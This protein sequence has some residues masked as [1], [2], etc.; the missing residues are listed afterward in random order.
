MSKVDKRPI[1]RDKIEKNEK[2][3]A[4]GAR[5]DSAGAQT[6]QSKT[7]TYIFKDGSRYEGEYKEI[8]GGVIVR[9]GVGKYTCGT[10]KSVYIGAW[11]LD[12]MHGKGRLEFA[13]GAF[14]DGMWKENQYT[15]PGTYRWPDSSTF[16]GEW[17]E[18]GMNGPG[19]YT[20]ASGQG[21]IGAIFKGARATL[22]PELQ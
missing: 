2:A 11:E 16:V 7:G 18:N 20:D 21:W 9:S 3:G 17:L 10:T 15:G 22:A 8:E 12:K 19:K 5:P 1:T 13:S 4:K 14:Y 6:N